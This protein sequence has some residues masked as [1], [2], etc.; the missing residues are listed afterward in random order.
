MLRLIFIASLIFIA[1]PAFADSID[2]SW[3]AEDGKHLN[4]NGPEITLPNDVK[5]QGTY[6]RHEFLYT[7]PSGD[8]DSG[9]QIYL[10]LQ[11]EDAMNSYPIKNNKPGDATNW[12]RCAIPP[13]TS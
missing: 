8:P 5:I 3:C 4:I 11:S 13:K 7:A 6:R 12:E 2:G 1:A 9:T 10:R